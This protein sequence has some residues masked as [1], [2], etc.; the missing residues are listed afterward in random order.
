M[1]CTIDSDPGVFTDLISHMGVKGVQVEELYTL[2]KEAVNLIKPV[3]GLVFLF[4]WSPNA[5]S[6]MPTTT[7]T[8]TPAAA[9]A[10]PSSSVG[11]TSSLRQQPQPPPPPQ[12]QPQSQPAGPGAVQTQN[13]TATINT[14]GHHH[15]HQE[16][17]N[18]NSSSS[19]NINNNNNNNNNNNED[20]D[21]FF[22]FCMFAYP[23]VFFANQVTN[24]ACATQA[25]L[26][27]LMNLP[28]EAAGEGVSLGEELTTFK[29]FTKDLPPKMKG[30]A[31]SNSD[32]IRNAHNSFAVA[33]HVVFERDD[34]SPVRDDDDVFHFTAYVPID[35]VLYELDGL[36]A[37]PIR[38]GEV[39][40]TPGT[41]WTDAAF[42]VIQRRI[43]RYKQGEMHFNLMALI[44]SR[45]DV[46]TEQIEELNARML[47]LGG[48]GG[49]V[50]DDARA[51]IEAEIAAKE[52]LLA[53][54][55]EKA[56]K[57]KAENVRRKWDYFPFVANLLKALAE[58]GDL[59][60]L[61]SQAAAELEQEQEKKLQQQKQKQQQQQ[62]QQSP[63]PPPPSQPTQ[64]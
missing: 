29:E 28:P 21:D 8:T 64:Q 25:I 60:V 63:L 50:D 32:T 56:R 10:A 54:E 37:E 18:G 35:G 22:N 27:I 1:W 11:P 61:L 42:P 23:N 33:D 17:S 36:K 26:S 13:S 40:T 52:A 41:Y 53:A 62:Q 47:S 3:Y 30:L 15:R 59:E 55:E 49:G 16:Q 12:P 51:V 48:G 2:D 4:R 7:T 45:R 14:P 46:I 57:W 58:S 39:P 24:N 31:I 9:A 6:S 34:D 43:E 38:L 44:R 19:S 20:D 5:P